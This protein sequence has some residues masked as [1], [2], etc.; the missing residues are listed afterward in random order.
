MRTELY[1]TLYDAESA[2]GA[3]AADHGGLVVGMDFMELPLRG[4]FEPSRADYT[5]LRYLRHVDWDPERVDAVRVVDG[6][7][8]ET[9]GLF[10]YVED[11]ID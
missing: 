7:T 4:G 5:D 9:I 11:E 6:E 8:R 2:A 10:G 1:Y 3:F